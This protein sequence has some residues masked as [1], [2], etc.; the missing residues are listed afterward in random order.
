MRF[1]G[2]PTLH[3]T[4]QHRRLETL[5][6][7]ERDTIVCVVQEKLHGANLSLW[8]DGKTVRLAKRT[9]FLKPKEAFFG[10]HALLPDLEE[11][12]LA[13]FHGLHAE[14][15]TRSVAIFGELIGGGY[16]HPDVAP[17]PTATL[18]QRGVYYCP[19]NT[20]VAFDILHNGN[21]FLGVDQANSLL[22]SHGIQH[23][24]TLFR[25]SLGK[26]L[27]YP[28]RF[29]T[30]FPTRLGLP[31]IED[32]LCEGVVIRD[33]RQAAQKDAGRM[34]FKNKNARFQE[35]DPAVA[36]ALK[37]SKQFKKLKPHLREPA[38]QL[39]A[40]VCRARLANV[41]SKF[42]A[43]QERDLPR[44]ARNLK[45]DVLNAFNQDHEGLFSRLSRHDQQRLDVLLNQHVHK[46]MDQHTFAILDGTF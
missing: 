21:I 7:H 24:E 32:N 2:Y 14:R 25:G 46:L 16:P 22:K 11:H 18:V 6:P 37:Q 20:F 28:N 45:T 9:A 5:S 15:P 19:Y 26:A 33:V 12:V 29:I 41:L 3:R 13:L 34:V 23:A 43:V 39:A 31:P 44:L 1:K 42:G 27:D 8:T 40:M 35:K 36:K 10:A 17:D 30:S 38:A 4:A